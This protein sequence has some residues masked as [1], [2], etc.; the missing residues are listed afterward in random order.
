MSDG[1][2]E[3]NDLVR[4]RVGAI[5]LDPYTNVP[6]IILKDDED[7]HT[8]PIWI[9]L[10]EASAIA[11]KLENVEVSRPLTHDL[12]KN[13]LGLLNA[14]VDRIEVVDLR[15]NTFFAVVQLR[16]GDEVLE[17]DSR[18]SDA[19]ALALRTESPIF[20][21]RRV[22]DKS[23]KLDDRNLPSFSEENK[24]KWA[25]ILEDLDPEDFSKYKM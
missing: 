23:Q 20:V 2:I 4:M 5:M 9:G 19:I 25:E 21:H 18:P 3:E 11:V 10:V 13:I 24:D 7:K 17:V 1:K 22:I 14:S 12:L 6:I 15:N 8:V 16:V